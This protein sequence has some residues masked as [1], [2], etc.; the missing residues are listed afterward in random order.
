[1]A[2]KAANRVVESNNSNKV[3]ELGKYYHLEPYE[4]ICDINETYIPAELRYSYTVTTDEGTVEKYGVKALELDCI[5]VNKKEVRLTDVDV[6]LID[7]EDEVVS[8]MTISYKCIPSNNVVSYCIN[9]DTVKTLYESLDKKHWSKEG[10]VPKEG[11]TVIVSFEY[12]KYVESTSGET[13]TSVGIHHEAIDI[14]PCNWEENLNCGG[15]LV[16]EIE[17]KQP[18]EKNC[19]IVEYTVNQEKCSNEDEKVD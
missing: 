6:K 3:F 8:T 15:K 16:G 10:I 5:N 11:G 17:F 9:K 4:N 14:P 2:K 13:T 12:T 18:H 7:G 19:N 1:M